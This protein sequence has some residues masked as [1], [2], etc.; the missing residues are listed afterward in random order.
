M[1]LVV[2]PLNCGDKGQPVNM[3]QKEI[4]GII[5]VVCNA[6]KVEPRLNGLFADF[7][8]IESA[9]RGSRVNVQVTEQQPRALF[10][11]LY[12][13]FNLN[14]ALNNVIGADY[15]IPFARL[16]FLRKIAL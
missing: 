7:G 14:A 10:F 3:R 1:P 13:V 2:S 5:V 11:K 9:V 12:C 4:L 8:D 15:D 6:D 16:D